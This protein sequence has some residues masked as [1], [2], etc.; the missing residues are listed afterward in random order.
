MTTM[1]FER[2][3]DV[4]VL[5]HGDQDPSD[6][7]WNSYVELANNSQRGESPVGGLLVTTFGGAPNAVQRKAI[8]EVGAIRRVVT[9]VCTNSVIARGVITAIRWLLDA[10]MHG[11]RLDQVDEALL[12]L[13][14]PA[15]E[16]PVVKAVVSRLQSQLS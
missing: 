15:Q 3:G 13:G 11:L 16:H 14:V 4:L 1:L 12:L 7:E 5:V 6:V 9:C 10:P 2:V 8:V